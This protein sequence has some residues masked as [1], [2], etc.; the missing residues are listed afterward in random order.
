MKWIRIIFILLFMGLL[1]FPLV[2]NYA[3]FF[4]RTYEGIVPTVPRIIL[5]RLD[6]YPKQF[7]DYFDNSLEIKPFLVTAN[8]ELKVRALHVSPDPEKIVLGRHGWLFMG[9]RHVDQFRGTNLFSAAEL[10]SFKRILD[11]R[12]IYAREK[13]GSRFYFLLAP[14]KHTIY[15]EFLPSSVKKVTGKTRYDQ[16]LEL[17]KNDTLIR[18]V[19]LRTDLLKLK[20]SHILYYKTD[21]HW[22]DIGGWIAYNRIYQLLH[23]DFHNIPMTDKSIFVM[24]S[25]ETLVGGEAAMMNAGETYSEQRFDYKVTERCKAKEGPKHGYKAP[26]EFP[27][28]DDFEH[29]KFT[30]DTSLPNAL[31]IRDSFTDAILPFLE[32]NFNRSVYIFDSW[33]YRSNREVLEN[34]KPQ[35]VMYIVLE[36]NLNALFETE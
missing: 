15:P 32:E 13:Y 18:T 25:S 36:S 6:A 8:S 2:N 31:I 27:W 16:V 22:N 30:G 29:L 26:P 7:E 24:D 23:E 3:H 33:H 1:Y 28:P 19:D 11:N 5:N 20:S 4:M 12:A 10:V 21:N 9:G 35:V 17:L 34:E 14:L